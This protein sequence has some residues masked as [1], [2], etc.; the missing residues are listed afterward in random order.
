MV[1]A[2]LDRRNEQGDFAYARD[3]R[4][5][6]DTAEVP[7]LIRNALT[8]QIDGNMVVLLSAPATYLARVLDLLGAPELIAAKVK[9]L[10][11]CDTGSPQDIP[12]MRKLLAAWPSPIVLCGREVGEALP[13]PGSSLD[14]D[15]AWTPAHPV[16][17]AYR[18]YHAMPYD[19]PSWDMAAVCYAAHPDSGLF[20]TSEPGTIEVSADG[21]SKFTPSPGG[22]HRSIVVDPARKDEIV[23]VYRELASA[24]PVPR[25]PVRPKKA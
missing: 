18:A 14:Q 9:T 19:A 25:P 7:A 8:T 22:K 11:M 13:F 16:A 2:A 10:V 17:D 24:K 6:S 20:Q 21:R 3:I 15:F 5:V 12:S 23:R 4:K 1:R